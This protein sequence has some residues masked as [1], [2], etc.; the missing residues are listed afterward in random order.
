MCSLSAFHYNL[1]TSHMMLELKLLKKAVQF[2]QEDC[3]RFTCT[4]HPRSILLTEAVSYGIRHVEGALISLAAHLI[5]TPCPH[6]KPADTAQTHQTPVPGILA[7]QTALTSL[8][9]ST[10]RDRWNLWGRWNNLMG[11]FKL[12]VPWL[13][14]RKFSMSL[15]Q[16][17]D[18]NH[19][20]SK[21]VH[22]P[23]RIWSLMAY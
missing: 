10:Y 9:T 23:L 12:L 17:P 8:A 2:L 21:K 19:A 1:C 4:G 22:A 18:T 3:C 13:W 14:H 11:C 5:A 15:V 7:L 6:K 20:V 16:G